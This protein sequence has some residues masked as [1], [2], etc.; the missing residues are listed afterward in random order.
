MGDLTP[1]SPFFYFP[2]AH[3]FIKKKNFLFYYLYL[4][5]IGESKMKSIKISDDLHQEIKIWVAK[6]NIKLGEWVE[7]ALQNRVDTLFC[8]KP[9]EN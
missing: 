9:E 4:T 3:L 1:V 8:I 6:Q 5:E 7:A 2:K